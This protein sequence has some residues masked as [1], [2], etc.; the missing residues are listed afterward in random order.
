VDKN[1]FNLLLKDFVSSSS[2]E[3]DHILALSKQY[4]Y[5]QVL[6]ALIAR[7]SHD[8]SWSSHQQLLQTAAVYSTDR[9]VLKDVI[10]KLHPIVIAPVQYSVETIEKPVKK[11]PVDYAEEVIHDLEKLTQL[12]KDFEHLFIEEAG[13]PSTGIESSEPPAAQ[14]VKAKSTSPRKSSKR[15]RLIELARELNTRETESKEET[16]ST[17]QELDPLIEEL[18][19]TRNE[20]QPQNDKTKEQI[21]LID[22]FI[23]TSGSRVQPKSTE[24]ENEDLASSL[25]SGVFSDNIVSETLAEILVRQGKKEKAIEVYKKLIWKFPQK[26]AYFAAQIE[27]LKK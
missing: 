19:S 26:K 12:R 2:L 5:C 24:K 22:Q 8:H 21:E 6:H 15:Q 9:A 27:E 4:P 10:T 20:I 18:Q 13:K 23:K 7:M 14:E 1:Q 3:A 11:G 16:Q 17:Q 25:K